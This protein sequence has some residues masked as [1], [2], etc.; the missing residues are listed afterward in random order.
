MNLLAKFSNVLFKR[1]GLS[2]Q[3]IEEADFLG[4]SFRTVKGT[5]RNKPDYD[6]AW[7]LALAYH[8]KLVFDVGCNVGPAGFLLLYP[9]KIQRIVFVDANAQAL[10]V[11]AKNMMLNN[12]SHKAQFIC[13]F[14]SDTMGERIPFYTLGTGAAGSIYKTHAKSAAA[15]DEFILVPQITLD[16]LSEWYQFV[17]DLVKIDVEG[18]EYEVLLGASGFAKL[19]KTKF[20]VEMHSNEE[21][22]MRD[23]AKNILQWCE[24]N[25]YTA[26]YLKE[27]TVLHSPSMIEGRGRCHLL[28]IPDGEQF[29]AFLTSLEQSADLQKVILSNSEM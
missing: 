12:L 18:A 23:N 5:I 24:M 19:H 7:L 28:L 9:E 2:Y 13:A 25:R 8:S 11:A 14:A 10:A 29:P 27:K 21:L 26:W 6:D 20:F 15:L 1:F 17:P 3:P 22:P 4:R 16:W